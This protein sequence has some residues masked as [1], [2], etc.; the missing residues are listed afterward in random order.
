MSTTAIDFLKQLRP[1]GPWTLTA[2]VPDGTTLTRAFDDETKAAQFI[3]KYNGQRNLYYSINP[4]RDGI[5]K[6]ASKADITAGEF[7]H[8]DLDPKDGETPDAAK[9]R[10]LA[11]LET[12]EPHCTALVDSGNGIQAAWRLSSALGPEH[13]DK[14]EALSKAITLTLG[15]TAGTQNIDRILRLPGTINLPNKKKLRAGRVK[16]ET[17]LIKFNGAAAALEDF[18][19]EVPKPGAPPSSD[20][21]EINA[22]PI[23]A[24]MKNLIRGIDDPEH[25]YDSRS[26]RVM[27]VMMA[28]AGADCTDEQFTSV[29]L[30]R[31]NAISEHVFEQ[32]NPEAYVLKHIVKARLAVID[33][34]VAAVN[35]TY[36][37]VL[38]GGTSAVMKSKPDHSFELLK[39]GAF[40]QWHAN[41]QVYRTIGGN[42]EA[43]PLAKYWNSHKQRR[44]YEGIV[45][46][47][48]LDVPGY[49]NLW[50]GFAVEPRP[51][52]CSKFKAHL[53]DNV[54]GEHFA[55]G[56]GW[57]A[58]MFQHPEKKMGT[59]IA[60]RGRQG[61]GKT[62]VGE[63]VG[64]LMP[65]HYVAVSDPRY[66]TGRFNSH[67][68]SCILLLADEAFWAGDKQAEGKLKDLITG[69][70]QFIEYKGK[71]PVSV[72]NYVRL[73]VSGN[74]DWQ[75]PA[76]YEERRF[77]IFDVSEA[78]M[79]D[80]DYF[81]AIDKEM[82]NGG[83]EAL[84]YEL[85]NFDLSTVNLRQIPKTGALLEQKIASQDDR[86]G[87][88]LDFLHR[89]ELPKA[90]GDNRSP[91]DAIQQSY[92]N[93]AQ[94]HHPSKRRAIETALGMFLHK[95]APGL[96]K[97]E[98][99]AIGWTRVPKA[100]GTTVDGSP[101]Y[102]HAYEFPSLKVCRDKFVE[103]IQQQIHWDTKTDWGESDQDESM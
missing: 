45:F 54:F 78:H 22:L 17:S 14:I 55:W 96:K 28:M 37:L 66:V 27:A 41:K 81:A 60:T 71:E 30:N 20:S 25:P 72:D 39:P 16:C 7:V 13:F 43:I 68:V 92:L 4:T 76:G 74:H 33:T 47:P 77:A 103:K 1:N 63:V 87:W 56:F 52:D 34:D 44:Q 73:L 19:V 29:F 79:Q 95:W 67:L 90:C 21:E 9:Q 85:L 2:I 64:S 62:K 70:K 83:R 46:K 11:A 69:E 31:Q 65:Y 18:K 75:V 24:R 5:D 98:H 59:A 51:G 84:L 86:Q 10:Y 3:A 48:K 12:F 91:T 49:C 101:I 88:W 35:Q 100:D 38:V 53:R 80:H 26:E 36:A 89:G 6:K 58:Q 61:V 15:G 23:S 32:G 50:R 8:A 40:S 102:G 42:V 93:H 94:K 82:D 97:H 99:V 57:L